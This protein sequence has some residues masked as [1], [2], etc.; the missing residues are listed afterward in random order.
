MEPLGRYDERCVIRLRRYESD[1]VITRTAAEAMGARPILDTNDII[2]EIE[3]TSR[4]HLP[5]QTIRLDRWLLSSS[6]R[7]CSAFYRRV[8]LEISPKP[9]DYSGG[10]RGTP[11]PVT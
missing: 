3:R 1:L 11:S 8:F 7:I 4:K 5:W 2:R 6:P 10:R 9:Q